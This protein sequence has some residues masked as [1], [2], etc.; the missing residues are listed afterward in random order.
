MTAVKGIVLAGGTGSR[1]WPVTRG[2][3]KQLI[4]IFDKPLIYYPISTLML[5]G[6]KDI[7]IITTPHDQELYLRLLGD[8]SSLGLSFSYRTQPNPD[9]IAQAFLI[10]ESFIQGENC[11]LILGDNLFFGVGLGSQLK[12]MT[13]NMGATIF[14]QRVKD[15]ERYAVV[16]VGHKN[17]IISLQEKPIVPKSNFAVPGLY[18]Y[19]NSVVEIAKQITRSQR[20]EFEITSINDE[21]LSRG[22]LNVEMLGRGTAWFDTGTFESLVAATNFVQAVEERQGTK[23]GCL[24]EIS[25]RNGWI[26]DEQILSLANEY[27]TSSYSEYL[28]GLVLE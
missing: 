24:E 4:P 23:I 18:F 8:G 20:G 7:L 14:A 6:I 13:F 17:Q 25:W 9:G 19:D 11:S 10:G 16:E 1:L 12:N 28:K 3:S 5:A 2:I 15:P 27:K 26:N 22:L 21:Y